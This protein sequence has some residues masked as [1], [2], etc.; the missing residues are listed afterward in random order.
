[1]TSPENSSQRTGQDIAHTSKPP[2][3]SMW[4]VG[5]APFVSGSGF[6]LLGTSDLV[7]RFLP[8]T[9]LAQEGIS[10]LMICLTGAAFAA[11]AVWGRRSIIPHVASPHRSHIDS[12]SRNWLLL[13]MLLVPLVL[14]PLVAA[15]AF[16]SYGRQPTPYSISDG[17]LVIPG[18]A[19]M[20]A[21][22]SLYNWR[23]RSEPLLLAFGIY[24]IGLAL[25]IWWLSLGSTERSGLLMAGTG[26]PLAVFGATRLRASLRA[27]SR[28]TEA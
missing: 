19:V 10:W 5:F 28:P 25:L 14:L 18:F 12:R 17:R 22:L 4:K 13:P 27:E 20:V 11:T 16:T 2:A 24:L 1:M 15:D 26:G 3:E 9:A 23:K 21:A 7:K 6:F 8:Q